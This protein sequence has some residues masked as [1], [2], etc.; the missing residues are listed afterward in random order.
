MCIKLEINQGYTMMHGQPVIKIDGL[1]WFEYQY[2]SSFCQ[3]VFDI[4]KIIDLF[5]AFKVFQ[6]VRLR[7]IIR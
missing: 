3:I 4:R 5:E 2:E 7:V 6:L 1:R